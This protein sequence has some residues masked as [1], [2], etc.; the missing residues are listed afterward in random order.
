MSSKKYCALISLVVGLSYLIIPTAI[1][2]TLEYPNLNNNPLL[3][4]EIRPS[5]LPY[6]LPIDHPMKAKLDTI[7]SWS[8]VTENEKTLVDAGFTIIAGPMP[9]SYI[10]VARHPAVPGYVFKLFLDSETRCRYDIPHWRWL[11]N[12]C[13]Q[14]RKIRKVIEHKKI[15][16]FTVADKWL[17]ILPVHPYSNAVNPD[18]VIL[19]ATD[20]EPESAEVSER[21]WKTVVTHKHLDELYAI[22]KHGYGGHDTFCLP[23]NVPYTKQ[24]KFAF[25]DTEKPQNSPQLKRVKKYISK[26]MR[27]YWEKLIN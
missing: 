23:V 22:L 21:M 8:R 18:P 15:R 25:I 24:G 2:A 13:G 5:I 3:P 4:D 7:F 6:L 26:D 20:L 11:A 12:R 1:N 17:Y 9:M 10:I 14:A 27:D 16:H 19:L